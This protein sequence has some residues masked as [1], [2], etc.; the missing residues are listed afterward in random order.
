MKYHWLGVTVQFM[1]IVQVS[2]CNYFNILGV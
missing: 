2:I 1:L